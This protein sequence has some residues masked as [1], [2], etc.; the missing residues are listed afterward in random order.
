MATLQET[1]EAF[2]QYVQAELFRRPFLNNDPA[3]E[4]VMVRRGGGPRQLA[5]ISIADGEVLANVGGTITGVPAGSLGGGGSAERKK[6][7]EQTV[8]ALTWTVTHTYSSVNVEVYVVDTD[9]KRVEPDD[10]QA[11]DNDTVVITFTQL[12]AGK[13]LLRWYD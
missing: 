3:Q 5:A 9:N 6:L 4:T 1:L 11:V 7:H 12:Q 13:A 2:V 8:P 10:I